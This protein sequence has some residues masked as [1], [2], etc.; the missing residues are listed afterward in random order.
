MI[1]KYIWAIEKSLYYRGVFI[2]GV[3]FKGG[4]HTSLKYSKLFLTKF[5]ARKRPFTLLETSST[6][7]R[8][9]WV[10]TFVME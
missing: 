1:K 2:L 10:R 5:H 9:S 8:V 3:S 7:V 4:T 6:T